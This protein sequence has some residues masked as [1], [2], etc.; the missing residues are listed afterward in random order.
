MANI[1]MGKP[2][3]NQI[4]QSFFT[5]EWIQGC[6]AF[7]VGLGIGF[8]SLVTLH[9]RAVNEC[10]ERTGIHHQYIINEN[11]DRACDT[12]IKYL[13]MIKQ[14]LMNMFQKLRKN[15]KGKINPQSIV[16]IIVAF[17]IF[18]VTF[19]IAMTQLDAATHTK[20]NAAVW[21]MFD[22]VL[23]VLAVVGV[24]LGFL[25]TR[26]KKG[27]MRNPI[28]ILA[29]WIE[30]L[31]SNHKGEMT[32]SDVVYIAIGILC[33]ALIFPIAMNNGI[34]GNTAVL[35]WAASPVYTLFVIVVP[36]IVVIAIAL[37]FIPHGGKK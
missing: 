19:M 20:W 9:T 23:P 36:I 30:K 3:G 21:T 10:Y 28:Q 15:I 22:T 6:A 26:G 27:T 24:I 32:V 11:I 1:E 37:Q 31:K 8:L 7:T 14:I 4:L 2:G 17:F 33:V 5:P 18:A 25:S 35:T 29:N 13:R 16:M 12:G 34:F